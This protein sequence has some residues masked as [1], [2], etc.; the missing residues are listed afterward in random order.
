MKDDFT[1]NS[2]H[3]THTFLLKGAGE[4]VPFELGSERIHEMVV[5]TMAT[6]VWTCVCEWKKI[7]N[8]FYE[9]PLLAWGLKMSE[10]TQLQYT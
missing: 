8:L 6:F 7:R 5:T 10:I 3:L 2:L 9:S 1:T 4:N